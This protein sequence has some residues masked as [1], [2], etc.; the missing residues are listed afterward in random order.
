MGKDMHFKIDPSFSEPVY[1]QIVRQVREAVA[2][3]RLKPGGRLPTVRDLALDLV[4][5]PNTVAAA[6]REME[7]TGLVSTQ[8]GRGTF[9]AA[10]SPPD[11][12][13]VRRRLAREHMHTF[14]TEAMHLGLTEQEC[15]ELL[16]SEAKR[17]RLKESGNE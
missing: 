7:R 9:V 1:A 16:K 12:A 8:R 4:L 13:S 5:N 3:G 17:F 10:P 6:Y 15:I 14:L 2:V 11:I